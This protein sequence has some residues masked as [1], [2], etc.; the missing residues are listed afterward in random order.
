MLL[1]RRGP[2]PL[3]TLLSLSPLP[4]PTL[5]QNSDLDGNTAL[6]YA[7][8]Y[9][10]RKCVRELL[11]MGANPGVRNR[12]FWTPVS[13]SFTVQAEVYLNGLVGEVRRPRRDLGGGGGG[14]VRLVGGE[15]GMGMGRRRA[16]S[17][18]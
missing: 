1:A 4:A 13:Y 3:P 10:N 5:L 7:S 9:G 8:A 12:W 16:G 17:A 6:H 18:E 15:D 14:G 2:T 11:E